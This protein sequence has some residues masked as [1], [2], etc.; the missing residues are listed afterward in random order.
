M[1][2]L[3]PA[4][5]AG[6]TANALRYRQ[7]LGRVPVL[8]ERSADDIVLA[9]SAEASDGEYV[10][11]VAR[12]VRVPLQTQIAALRHAASRQ[13]LV[14]DLVPAALPADRLLALLRAVD[15]ATYTGDPLAAGRSAGHALVLHRSVVERAGIDPDHERST[16]ELLELASSL[17][18]YAPWASGFAIA[19]SLPAVAASGALWDQQYAAFGGL[20][21]GMLV[22]RT[23][24]LTGLAVAALRGGRPGLAALA[25]YQ[26]QP[27]LVATGTPAAGRE[28]RQLAATRALTSAA[29]I[30]RTARSRRD[31]VTDPVADVQARRADY[32]DAAVATT[33]PEE[34]LEPRRDDCPLCA[35]TDL[36]R[37]ADV[38]DLI[39][40]K[41]G[42]FHVDECGGCGLLFQNPRLTIPGLDFYYRDFYDGLAAK[43]MEATFSSSRDSYQGRVDLISSATTPQRLLDVGTGQGHFCL[44]AREMWPEAEIHGLDFTPNVDL[45][46]RRGWIDQ[47]HNGLFPDLAPK[48]RGEFDVVS[49]HHY[50]EHTRDPGAEL[51]AAAEV[52]A[53]GGYL[54][55]EVPNPES[56]LGR[57]LGRYWV[58][59]LQP[60]HQMLITLSSLSGMLRERGFTVVATQ[61]AEAHQP[62]DLGV[63]AFLLTNRIAPP[64][65][66]PWSPPPTRARRILRTTLSVGLFPLLLVGYTLDGLL[67]PVIANTG[68]ASAYRILARKEE[69]ADA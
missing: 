63:A 18:L 47:A 30:V 40:G 45:A 27:M 20:T 49:M 14:L 68:S 46:E 28:R 53:P 35:S 52:V 31:A 58:A 50:L 19:P 56:R 8:D 69:T 57:A 34:L 54:E 11:V 29:D 16:F 39:Q 51:D 15:P 36:S 17:K 55:I 25:A 22:A 66:V 41:P 32:H 33:R 10:L 62:A 43:Q 23:V 7:R 67:K 3:L 6:L 13:F 44:I 42:I 65:D 5:A 48:L 24:A 37:H 12:G 38:P 61:V 26:L 64:V 21:G 59:L 2:L 9:G 4:V 60:Q 1:K